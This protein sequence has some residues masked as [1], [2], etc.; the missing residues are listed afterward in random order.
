MDSVISQRLQNIQVKWY[1]YHS[2][3]LKG[4]VQLTPMSNQFQV[5]SDELIYFY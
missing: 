2:L 4:F 5:I 3:D 1:K